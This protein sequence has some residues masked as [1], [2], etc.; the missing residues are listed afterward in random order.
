MSEALL[1]DPE[2]L[3]RIH[4]LL[5]K[6]LKDFDDTCRRLDIPY[7]VYGGTM[8]G[9]I[10]HQGFIPW[11][12]DVDVLMTRADYER[13]LAEAPCRTAIRSTTPEPAPSTPSCSPSSA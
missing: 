3:R 5:L 11:D 9:A 2:L 8:I 4:A 12:D 13:F 1:D 10:R 6:M 7:S